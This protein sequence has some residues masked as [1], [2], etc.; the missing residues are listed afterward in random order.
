MQE[1]A[2][3]ADTN[4]ARN[5]LATN[6]INIQLSHQPAPQA[7]CSIPP[8]PLLCE[9]QV[10]TQAQ[11]QTPNI[12]PP[13]ATETT[14]TSISNTANP[15]PK[16]RAQRKIRRRIRRICHKCETLFSGKS[17]LVCQ[18]RIC[19]QCGELELGQRGPMRW[20]GR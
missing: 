4:F 18:H 9:S 16:S 3:Y 8:S 19:T 15:K 12:P 7:A 17:C 14:S 1:H 5:V 6:Q 10:P 20:I 2:P 11:A 13:T